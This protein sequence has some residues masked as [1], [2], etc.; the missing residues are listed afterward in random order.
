MTEQPRIL[1]IEDDPGFVSLLQQ[2]LE[3]QLAAEVVV[4]RDGASARDA[5]A[6]SSFDLITLAYQLPDS[7]GIEVLEEIGSKD[8]RT[9]V[10]IITG[11]GDEATA[12]RAFKAGAAGYVVKDRRLAR[13][14]P[15]V[16]G[17]ALHTARLENA[18]HDSEIRYRRLF[19]AAEDG[20][21]AP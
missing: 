3:D 13:L 6:S 12:A 18:L 4:V 17:K 11:Q 9:P 14:L 7:D 16:L 20:D 10:I 21:P 8:Q 15:S 2:L 1:V 19:E 5:I